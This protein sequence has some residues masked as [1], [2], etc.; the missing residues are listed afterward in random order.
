MA[1]ANRTNDYVLTY[2]EI[3]YSLDCLHYLRNPIPVTLWKTAEVLGLDPKVQ[4]LYKTELDYDK[5]TDQIDKALNDYCS[6]ENN[7]ADLGLIS[8]YSD[9]WV[10]ALPNKDRLVCNPSSIRFSESQV[11]DVKRYEQEKSQNESEFEKE[12][13]NRHK[14]RRYC[15]LTKFVYHLLE[16]KDSTSEKEGK[17]YINKFI[18]KCLKEAFAE[19]NNDELFVKLNQQCG[20]GKNGLDPDQELKPFYK[21]VKRWRGDSC[22]TYGIQENSKNG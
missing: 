16:N 2:A 13:L 1:A 20:C 12:I 6:K 8:S 22:D 21:A 3:T 19:L 9:Q 10:P 18:D 17:E 7:F 5:L 4:D 14:I 15:I 11:E